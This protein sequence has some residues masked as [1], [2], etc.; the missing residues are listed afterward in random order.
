MD[1]KQ[2][3]NG[4]ASKGVMKETLLNVLNKKNANQKDNHPEGVYCDENGCYF[5]KK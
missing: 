5:K 4:A 1:G 2:V 3:I